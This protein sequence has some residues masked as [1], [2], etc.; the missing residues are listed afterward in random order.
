M[1]VNLLFARNIYVNISD[2]DAPCGRCKTIYSYVPI[3]IAYYLKTQE[4][5]YEP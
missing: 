5:G 4:L 2:D 1:T 3:T